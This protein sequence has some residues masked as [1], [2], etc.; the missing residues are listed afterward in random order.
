MSRS[1]EEEEADIQRVIFYAES[2]E[3]PV[4][5]QIA[6]LYNVPYQRLLAR[7]NGRGDRFQNGGHN[8][9]LSI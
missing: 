6:I 9:A 2:I 1:Y 3:K 5:I 4:W 7:I 8:K